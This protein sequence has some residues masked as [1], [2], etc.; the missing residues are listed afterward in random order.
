MGF[1]SVYAGFCPQG[2]HSDSSP[3]DRGMRSLEAG[4]AVAWNF[5]PEHARGPK[6]ILGGA[7]QKT[8]PACEC[9]LEDAQERD[10]VRFLLRRE[11]KA[12]AELIKMHG[13]KECL[14]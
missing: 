1:V 14:C 9:S 10:Q 8:T 12:K 13:V 6:M 11:N 2:K 3:A 7:A 4:S 5:S